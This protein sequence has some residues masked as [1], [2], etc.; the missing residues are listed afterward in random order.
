[1]GN[2]RCILDCLALDWEKKIQLTL[3]CM[4]VQNAGNHE[5]RNTFVFSSYRKS[6]AVRYTLSITWHS[7]YK[8]LQS[9]T[10]M[11]TGE[12]ILMAHKHKRKWNQRKISDQTNKSPNQSEPEKLWMC[13]L[14]MFVHDC[15]WAMNKSELCIFIEECLIK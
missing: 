7:I 8:S 12:R 11:T 9:W 4:F 13:M 2:Y 10:N 6:L 1:M 15:V 5:N 14:K 3:C